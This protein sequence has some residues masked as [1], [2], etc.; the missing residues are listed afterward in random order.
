[1]QSPKSYIH[2]FTHYCHF[3]WPM[4]FLATS[5]LHLRGLLVFIGSHWEHRQLY[6][7]RNGIPMSQRVIPVNPMQINI[8]KF[9]EILQHALRQAIRTDFWSHC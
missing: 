3:P 8:Q 9:K 7:E 4:D 2:Y 1:M 6:I 5:S